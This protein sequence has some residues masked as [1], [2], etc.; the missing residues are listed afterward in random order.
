MPLRV[1]LRI[2]RGVVGA[3]IPVSV[4]APVV[5]TSVVIGRRRIGGVCV[6]LHVFVIVEVYG[7]FGSGHG[8]WLSG[9]RLG[10]GTGGLGTRASGRAD[11]RGAVGE[12]LDLV[13]GEDSEDGNVFGTAGGR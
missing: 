7:F 5:G 2:L 6:A 11:S 12:V 1:L 8:D 9:A 13:D 3:A 10:D 4:A